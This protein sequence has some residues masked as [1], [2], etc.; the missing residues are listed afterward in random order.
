MAPSSVAAGSSSQGV[1]TMRASALMERRSSMLFSSFSGVVIWVRES[2]MHSAEAI[3]SVKNSPKLRAY[4]RQRFTSATVA[5]ASR[6]IS[7][8]CARPAI[9]LRTSESLP[10]P[11]GSMITRSG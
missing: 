9:T 4:T 1:V 5:Q 6:E 2:T 7:I 10:T 11:E 3:W 8:S